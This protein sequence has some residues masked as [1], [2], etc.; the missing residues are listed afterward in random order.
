[1]RTHRKWVRRYCWKVGLYRQGLL[2]D[3]S[4]YSP[5]EFWRGVK[6]YQGGTSSPINAEKSASGHGYSEAWMHHKS[7]NKH[8]YEYW[9]DNLDDS[10]QY[11]M[12]PMVHPMPYKYFA[13]MLC[14]YLGAARAYLGDHFTYKD[15][16]IWWG[17]QRN[18][19]AMHEQNKIML[20]IIFTDLAVAAR[21][22]IAHPGWCPS[23]EQLLKNGYVETIYNANCSPWL[24]TNKYKEPAYIEYGG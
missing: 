19:R 6:Y 16:M 7:R 13:E 5:T 2:H 17:N 24:R 15:E 3:L 20:D 8:H 21:E 18:R 10:F 9:V 14:D 4:K 1:M 22:Q 12:V 11:G 23:P